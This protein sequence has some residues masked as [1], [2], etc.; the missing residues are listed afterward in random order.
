MGM[1]TIPK[2]VEKDCKFSDQELE[3]FIN[4]LA[5]LVVR[6]GMSVPVI[7]SLEM[8]K[9]ISFIGYSSLVVFGPILE[10]M[11]DSVKMEKLQAIS[12]DRNRIEQLMVAIETLEKEKK[13]CKE[14]ESR[15]QR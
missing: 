6:R 11:V 4:K 7:M 12:A 15:E 5:E 3:E 9:P 13:D 2:K 10:M 1:W 14:G 8:V